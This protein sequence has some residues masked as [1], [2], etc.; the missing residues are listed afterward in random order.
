MLKNLTLIK[1]VI[2]NVLKKLVGL[3]TKTKGNG[4]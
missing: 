1:K 2:A 3:L 4:N